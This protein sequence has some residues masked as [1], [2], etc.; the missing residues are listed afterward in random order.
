MWMQPKL[1]QQLYKL[2]LLWPAHVIWFV[3]VGAY[4]N[5]IMHLTDIAISYLT[6]W[7]NSG[8]ADHELQIILRIVW[9]DLI[10]ELVHQPLDTLLSLAP[11]HGWKGYL[12]IYNGDI[13]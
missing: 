2:N 9:V 10:L 8:I 11:W 12:I 7:R 13:V 1:N 4:T 3:P 6:L 5:F